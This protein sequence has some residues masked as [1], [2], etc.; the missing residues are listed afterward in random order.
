MLAAGRGFVGKQIARF[1]LVA[2]AAYEVVGAV[3]GVG[4]RVVVL[5]GRV[6]SSG[7]AML[8]RICS[9]GKREGCF[10]GM[11]M[12]EKAIVSTFSLAWSGRFGYICALASRIFWLCEDSPTQTKPVSR[13]S[14]V[15]SIILATLS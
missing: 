8:R 10:Y 1:E 3:G 5:H 13:L 6:L 9:G 4:E 14:R 2:E 11:C 15:C 7:G 12:G